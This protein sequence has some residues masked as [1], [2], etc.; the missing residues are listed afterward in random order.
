M[1]QRD[2]P[3]NL[4]T[5]AAILVSALTLKSSQCLTDDIRGVEA[6]T[7]RMKRELES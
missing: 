2:Y 1:S 4:S 7:K 6:V 3:C 5:I